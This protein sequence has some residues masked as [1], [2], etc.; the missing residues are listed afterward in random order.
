MLVR[1][2]FL[3]ALCVAG[4]PAR[5][6]DPPPPLAIRLACD[7]GPGIDGCLDESG[8]RYA[9]MAQLGYYPTEPAL[10]ADFAP[11]PSGPSPPPV[12]SRGRVVCC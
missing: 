3:G 7:H 6:A 12:A 5:A 2:V 1:F 10:I 9:L 8:F 11:L 4:A